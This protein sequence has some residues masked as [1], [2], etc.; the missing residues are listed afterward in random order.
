MVEDSSVFSGSL[1]ETD[2]SLFFLGDIDTPFIPKLYTKY[3]HLTVC[4]TKCVQK[5]I[6]VLCSN[7]EKLT[8]CYARTSTSHQ[9]KGLESQE[10]LLGKYCNQNDIECYEQFSD[11]NF[12][13]KLNSRPKFDEMMELVRSENVKIIICPNLSRIARSLK[14]LLEFIEELQFYGVEFISLSESLNINSIHGRLMISILGA[15]SQLEREML[16]EK[17]K[18]GLMNAKEKGVRLGR[19]RVID[20]DAVI[21]LSNKG[22]TMRERAQVQ[23]CSPSSVCRI[24]KMH[25]LSDLNG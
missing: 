20:R 11:F 7:M 23:K 15:V 18:I 14:L 3:K 21:T 9:A 16:A 19:E 5:K 25:Q 8:I 2:F 13:G 6:F 24:L 17:T 22:L 12:S 1:Y 4:V 10:R